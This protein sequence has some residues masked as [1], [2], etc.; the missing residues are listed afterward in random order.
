MG[1]VIGI[2]LLCGKHVP[3]NEVVKWRTDTVKELI[4]YEVTNRSKKEIVYLPKTVVRWL[5]EP[6]SNRLIC[7]SLI[8]VV[9][10]LGKVIATM[11]PDYIKNFPKAPKLLFAQFNKDSIRLDLL[12]TDG[13]VYSDIYPVDYSLNNY[14]YRDNEFFSSPKTKVKRRIETHTTLS[15]IG[16]TYFMSP[17]LEVRKDFDYGKINASISAGCYYRSLPVYVQGSLGVKLYGKKGR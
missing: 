11:H 13:D 5:H 8:K 6:N 1:I 15:L 16:S 14:G 10:S 17:G 2:L 9:D 7:D 4:P 12:K 3:E